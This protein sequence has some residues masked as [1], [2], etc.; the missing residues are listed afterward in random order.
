M[1]Q[2]SQL[3]D[4]ALDVSAMRFVFFFEIAQ[5]RLELGAQSTQAAGPA[6][7]SANHGGIHQELFPTDRNVQ[8]RLLGFG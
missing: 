5:L 1:F 8:G 4:A 3:L 7:A 6:I 2:A